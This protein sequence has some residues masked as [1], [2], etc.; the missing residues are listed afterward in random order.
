[1]EKIKSFAELAA[2]LGIAPEHIDA[3][4]NDQFVDY[5]SKVILTS[6][7]KRQE[8]IVVAQSLVLSI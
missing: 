2:D 7:Q 4:I 6:E 5:M 3:A 8:A 1:M